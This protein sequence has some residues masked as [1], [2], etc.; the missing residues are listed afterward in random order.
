MKHGRQF[1]ILFWIIY[2]SYMFIEMYTHAIN[3]NKNFHNQFKPIYAVKTTEINNYQ[4]YN[5]YKYEFKS[6]IQ[7]ILH[8]IISQ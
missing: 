4:L 2:I 8:Y 7:N 5:V 3:L 6:L 1:L